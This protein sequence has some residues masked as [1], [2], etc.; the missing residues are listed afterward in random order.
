MIRN[1]ITPLLPMKI[2]VF[3]IGWTFVLGITFSFAE[4]SDSDLAEDAVDF[5]TLWG[6]IL[7]S[8]VEEY[9]VLIN[10]QWFY[11]DELQE[12]I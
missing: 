6:M 12:L 2:K 9:S 5:H 7:Q 11:K 4:E 8:D 1:S 10:E 3:D